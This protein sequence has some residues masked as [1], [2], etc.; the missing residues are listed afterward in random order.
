LISYLG[1]SHGF[2]FVL[3]NVGKEH[4]VYGITAK[5]NF[6]LIKADS[7]ILQEMAATPAGGEA[8]ET[9]VTALKSR[10]L[11]IIADRVEDAENLTTVISLGADYAMGDF[12]GEPLEQLEDRTNIESFEI[13]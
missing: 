6:D 11:D 7:E 10:G 4:D 12:L 13:V 1:K 5:T 3:G 2:K 9:L 8:G